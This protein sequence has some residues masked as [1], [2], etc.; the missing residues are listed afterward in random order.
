MA[1]LKDG[2]TIGETQRYTQ[3]TLLILL[4][5]GTQPTDGVTMLVQAIYLLLQQTQRIKQQVIT[6]LMVTQC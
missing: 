2:T 5:I 1:Q 3:E 6:L 4:L